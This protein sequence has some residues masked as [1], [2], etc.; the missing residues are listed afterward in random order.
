MCQGLSHHTAPAQPPRLRLPALQPAPHRPP[1]PPCGRPSSAP[2]IFRLHPQSNVLLC[3]GS[4]GITDM[5]LSTA[6][7]SL[8]PTPSALF[9]GF[10]ARAVPSAPRPHGRPSSAP[11]ICRF[12]HRSNVLLCI[13]SSGVIDMLRPTASHS[14]HPSA[15][16]FGCQLC[17]PR[18]TARPALR[19]EREDRYALVHRIT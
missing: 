7:H 17:S 4:C 2:P 14:L 3:I 12:H 10:A 8:H 1:N 15:L 13:G 6:S 5:Q 18:R 16:G 19:G 11:P 9:A